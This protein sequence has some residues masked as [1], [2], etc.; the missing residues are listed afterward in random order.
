MGS[1]T[2]RDA[3][4]M[5]EGLHLFAMEVSERAAEE[6]VMIEKC[7]DQVDPSMQ[8]AN[9][10]R[11]VGVV[12]ALMLEQMGDRRAVEDSLPNAAWQELRKTQYEY[13]E[14]MKKI[15][16]ADDQLVK[17]QGGGSK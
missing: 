2:I 4:C 3:P 11:F 15:W 9:N 10:V 17:E 13:G 14:K 12:T 5:A 16:D 8:A 6:A 1:T 7:K